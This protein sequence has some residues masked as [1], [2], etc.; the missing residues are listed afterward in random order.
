MWNPSTKG[1]RGGPSAGVAVFVREHIGMRAP[2]KGG[3]LVGEGRGLVCVVDAPGYRPFIAASVYGYS[4]KGPTAAN[5]DLLRAVGV[6]I[7]CQGEDWQHVIG[8]DFNL[9]PEQ[10]V[11]I[12][13]AD[14]LNATIVSAECSRGT[15]RTPT[16]ARTI[17]YFLM[18][19]G[20]AMAVQ[21]V[22]VIEGAGIKT[23]VPV[24]VQ[25]YP[26]AAAMKALYVRPPPRIPREK[27]FGPLPV[28]MNWEEPRSAAE[29]AV[30]AARGSTRDKAEEILERAYKVWADVAEQELCDVTGAS[31]PKKGLRG[32]RPDVVWR[33]ILPEKNPKEGCPRTSMAMC[34][35]GIAQ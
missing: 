5:A 10:V 25:M 6:R 8:G 1:K 18:T 35:H 29:E 11:D 31:L 16:A 23:H 13:F 9:T 22:A 7:Q 20:M 24:A 34:L 12:G 2:P 32:L 4:G 17:D 26:R 19:D 15:C 27:V 28:P 33:S 14:Q 3:H 21:Q 30:R